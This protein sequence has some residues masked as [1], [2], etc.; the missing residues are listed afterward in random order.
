MVGELKHRGPDANGVW[1]HDGHIGFGHARLAV[2]DLSESGQQPM[3]SRDGRYTICYNGEI[4]NY[5]ALRGYLDKEGIALRGHSDTEVLLE[6]TSLWGLDWVVE[7]AHGMFSIAL[8]DN[9]NKELSLVRDRFGEKP[10]Y[11]GLLNGQF[12]FSSE[13]KSFRKHPDFVFNVDREALSAYVKYNYVPSPLCI[14]QGFRKLPA[15]SKIVGRS[16]AEL[17]ARTP[18]VYWHPTNVDRSPEATIDDFENELEQVVARQMVS[19]VPLGCFL[20]GGIDSSLIT[21]IAQRHST[22]PVDTFTIG[23]TEK[24]FDESEHASAVAKH[25]GTNHTEWIIGQGDVLNLIP[26]VART[27]DEPFADSSQLPTMLLSKMTRQNV[28]VCLSG[29]GGDELF[30]GYARY[31]KGEKI[32]SSFSRV[33]GP[34]RKSLDW[35]YRRRSLTDWVSSYNRIRK[36]LPLGISN[37]DDKLDKFGSLL[38]ASNVQEQLYDGL[39]THWGDPPSVVQQGVNYS[40]VSGKFRQDLSFMENM[41]MHDACHYLIDNIMVK[42]DR[43]AMGVSLESRAP[44]LDHKLFELAWRIPLETRRKDGVGKYPLRKILYKHVPQSLIERPKKGFS[45]PLAP[46]FRSELADWVGDTLDKGTLSRQGYFNAD[47]VHKYLN[48]HMAGVNDRHYHLWDILV[49]QE[50]LTNW[51]D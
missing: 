23:F 47:A 42:V 39:L 14:L 5:E 30:G 31:E 51:A 44:L 48:E 35:I 36:F 1:V 16:P 10:L 45:V 22:K 40:L 24:A 7:R 15:G 41:M 21:A 28:T 13:L 32:D 2:I 11:Y 6:C 12:V 27:Y 34:A 46:W 50:W 18:E 26:S 19:D 49:F 29:D 9:H 20:S 37:V 38:G 4:Y 3:H 8:W 43:A 25:L 33:P 17:F